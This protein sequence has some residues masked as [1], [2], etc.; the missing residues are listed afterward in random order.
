M[1]GLEHYLIVSAALLNGLLFRLG[2]EQ[3]APEVGL[4][5]ATGLVLFLVPVFYSLYLRGYQL[6]V[7]LLR[8][9]HITGARAS[10]EIKFPATAAAD[11]KTGF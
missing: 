4:L 10:D 5:L 8:A 11:R 7:M 3:R 2:I 1:V 9:L 6:A